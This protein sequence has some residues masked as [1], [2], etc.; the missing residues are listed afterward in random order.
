MNLE[1]L[2]PIIILIIIVVIASS[3]ILTVH[4]KR[5]PDPFNS[6]WTAI[7]DLQNQI[8]NIQLIPGPQGPP[9]VSGYEIIY[10]E[11]NVVNG[12]YTIELTCPDTKKVLGGGYSRDSSSVRV[13]QNYP[14]SNNTWVVVAD[15]PSG[16]DLLNLKAYATC[17]YAQ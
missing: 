16:A 13:L 7:N 2:R 12:I 11:I 6:V 17:A 14:K 9:G 1:K 10:D 3:M 5:G 8:N 4:A 15:F